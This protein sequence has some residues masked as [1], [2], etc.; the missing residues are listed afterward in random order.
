[1]CRKE[2]STTLCTAGPSFCIRPNEEAVITRHARIHGRRRTD[3][4]IGRPPAIQETITEG[5]HRVELSSTNNW[6]FCVWNCT[7][8]Q[9]AEKCSE[10]ANCTVAAVYDR[11]YF[12]DFRKDRRS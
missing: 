8:W 3:R 7:S 1:M 4:V 2:Q 11:R 6:L 10:K 9:D 5:S 12:V